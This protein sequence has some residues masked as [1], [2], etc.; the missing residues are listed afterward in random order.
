MTDPLDDYLDEFGARVEERARR[1]RRRP[2]VRRVTLAA[3]AAVLVAVGVVL[4]DSGSPT[5]PVDAVAAARKAI[6]PT[7]DEIVHLRIR[8]RLSADGEIGI[9]AP[10]TRRQ[11]QWV[12][13][14]PTRWRIAETTP[15][16]RGGGRSEYTYGAGAQAV[17]D[18]ERD[19]VTVT[20]GF[21]G[22]GP[23]A[24]PPGPFGSDPQRTLPELLR[25]G[26]VRDK[27]IVRAHG[28][29]VRRLVRVERPGRSGGMV[30]GR[31]LTYDV[32]PDTFAPVGGELRLVIR[33]RRR[34]ADGTFTENRPIALI[35]TFVVENYRR[36]PVTASTRQ[37][38][39]I[40]PP[41][42]TRLV[43][44]RLRRENRGRVR[45]ATCRVPEDRSLRCP[46]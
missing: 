46:R 12:A 26:D 33:S 31:R 42:G 1:R 16:H 25:S 17:W 9:S 6:T 34:A 4:L 13:A 27:G 45:V 32:D 36:I 23:A 18:T 8:S 44:Y 37:L 40:R 11:E 10:R 19:L 2:V 20:G 30:T 14:D 15:H 21:A 28:R 24:E 5:R 39:T 22:D 29:E 38:L 35:Q 43:R 7:A 3:A 41:A